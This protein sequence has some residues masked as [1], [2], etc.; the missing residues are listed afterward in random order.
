MDHAS[1]LRLRALK[2]NG[3][4]EELVVDSFALLRVEPTQRLSEIAPA[5][6]TRRFS[7]SRSSRNRR[8]AALPMGFRRELFHFFVSPCHGELNKIRSPQTIPYLPV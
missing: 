3:K 5:T 6:G 8:R 4:A 7:V 2:L 1:R